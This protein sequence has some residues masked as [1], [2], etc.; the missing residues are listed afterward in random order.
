VL[1]HADQ[2]VAAPDLDLAARQGQDH[3]PIVEG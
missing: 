2:V 1:T 3:P